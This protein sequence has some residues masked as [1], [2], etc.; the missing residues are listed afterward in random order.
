MVGDPD[1][2]PPALTQGLHPTRTPRRAP[3]P[4]GGGDRTAASAGPLSPCASKS[5]RRRAIRSAAARLSELLTPELRRTNYALGL[6]QAATH[7]LRQAA[8]V[9]AN[10]AKAFRVGAGGIGD[11]RQEVSCRAETVT[12]GC[13]IWKTVR[14]QVTKA[15]AA[16]LSLRKYRAR[17]AVPYG[18]PG[19]CCHASQV[20]NTAFPASFSEKRAPNSLA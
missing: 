1:H 4:D 18:R 9:L 15:R 19:S 17:M 16:G 5:A 20:C 8:S 14:N 7:R 11:G 2:R 10:F 13:G 12:Q 3:R 6:R